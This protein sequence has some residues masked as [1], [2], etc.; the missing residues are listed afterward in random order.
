MA[1]TAIATVKQQQRQCN[2]KCLQS[3]SHMFITIDSIDWDNIFGMFP[4]QFEIEGEF[5]LSK[6]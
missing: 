5:S 2:L 4:V 6:L 1:T 3:I